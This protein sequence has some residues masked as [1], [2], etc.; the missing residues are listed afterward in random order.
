MDSLL[1]SYHNLLMNHTAVTTTS[2]GETLVCKRLER[3][4]RAPGASDP[5]WS[6]SGQ[7]VRLLPG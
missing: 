1:L 7:V 2:R 4:A 3:K 5:I 6:L